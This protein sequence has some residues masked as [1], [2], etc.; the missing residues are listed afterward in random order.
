MA[1][2]ASGPITLDGLPDEAAWNDAPVATSC[3]IRSMTN[4]TVISSLRTPAGAKWDSQMS[5]EGRENN[6]NWDGI[7]DVVTKVTETGWYLEIRHS[8]PDAEIHRSRGPDL[9][10][11]LRAQ[12][13]AFERR[14]LLGT[15]PPHLR[16]RARVDGGHRRGH[17]RAATGQEPPFQAVRRQQLRTRWAASA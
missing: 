7:W 8:V 12:A 5:N 10:R 16:P 9:G 11:E 15:A 1:V 6:A 2:R 13:E 3:S 4:E 17:A 14:Q